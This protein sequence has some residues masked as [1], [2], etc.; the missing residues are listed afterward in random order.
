[1]AS[2]VSSSINNIDTAHHL[3]VHTSPTDLVIINVTNHLPIKLTPTNY[4]T[5]SKQMQSMLIGYGFLGYVTGSTPRPPPTIF[6]DGRDTENFVFAHWIHQDQL[7]L[8]AILGASDLDARTII[9]QAKTSC[10]A[11][12]HVHTAF[13]N[14]SR[15]RVLYLKEKLS[16]TTK[17]TS[18]VFEYLR[19]IKLISDELS[20]IGYP[21]DDI[22]L[23]L[24]YLSGLGLDFKDIATILRA[25]PSSLTYDQ[26]YEQLVNHEL[27]LTRETHLLDG[28][29]T[30]NYVHRR[31]PKSFSNSSSHNI[32][33][34]SSRPHF[35]NKNKSD[36][37]QWCNKRGHFARFCF[38][39]ANNPNVKPTAI[40]AATLP[41]Q[42]SH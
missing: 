1:M 18:F 2:S 17:G 25:Q 8:L 19:S 10:Q 39:I 13:A 40:N 7:L 34:G 4:V 16:L 21:L 42:S 24:Y 14:R 26:I 27:Q 37:C 28:P 22:D 6:V 35:S 38:K 12:D 5:W 9:S 15:S 23:V 29:V 32:N 20:L 11:W 36:V 30:A 33:S 31:F 41:K 3:P